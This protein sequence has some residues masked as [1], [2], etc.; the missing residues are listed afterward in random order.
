MEYRKLLKL[1]LLIFLIALATFL[2]YY[3]FDDNKANPKEEISSILKAS[4]CDAVAFC[5]TETSELQE[6]KRRTRTINTITNADDFFIQ[7]PI[8]K[9]Q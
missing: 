1:L 9:N 7:H 8:K 6:E 3:V 5:P 2:F 4:V